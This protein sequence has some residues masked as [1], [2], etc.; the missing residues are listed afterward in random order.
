[1]AS[2]QDY[3]V[4]LTNWKQQWLLVQYGP[5]ALLGGTFGHNAGQIF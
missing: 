4:L 3:A 1:M 5:C 2:V